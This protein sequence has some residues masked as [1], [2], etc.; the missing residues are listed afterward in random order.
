MIPQLRV[1]LQ[2][3]ATWSIHCHDLRATCHIAGCSQLAKSVSW[4]CHIAGYNN[5]I[6]HVEIMFCHIFLF[7]SNAVWAFK[8]GRFRI[9]SDTVVILQR[10]IL[11][12]LECVECVVIPKFS[13]I[14]V[15][16]QLRQP[17]LRLRLNIIK[18]C[19]VHLYYPMMKN[20]SVY[21][22]L[23]KNTDTWWM[24]RHLATA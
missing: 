23:E 2:G 16:V 7:L 9:V 11:V 6:R 10:C 13:W 4:S 5:S 20:L 17:K 1:T 22:C 8:S 12:K 19:S 18:A 21:N 3:A 14:S 24:D 15:L